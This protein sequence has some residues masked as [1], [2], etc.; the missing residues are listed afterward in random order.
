MQILNKYYIFEV[1]GIIRE[2]KGG[3]RKVTEREAEGR[4]GERKSAPLSL[5]NVNHFKF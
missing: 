1:L 3:E 5:D 4:R 2:K